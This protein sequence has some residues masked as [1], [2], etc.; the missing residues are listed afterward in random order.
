MKTLLLFFGLSPVAGAYAQDT[1]HGNL[2]EAV[3]E[4]FSSHVLWKAAPASVAVIGS[5]EMNRYAGTSL[6]PV[7][8]TVAG[9]RMEERSPASYRLSFRGSLLRSPFGV[10]NIKV[11]WNDIP[12][13]DGGGNTYLN[14]IDI[15]QVTG[16]EVIK[17]PA[18]S[19]YGA[20]TGGAL[21]LQSA[22]AYADTSA[23]RF[24]FGITGGSYGLFS[25]QYSWN[26]SD[27]H[28]A[29]SFQQLHQQSD[30]Y[31]EQSATRRDA[32]KWE[33]GIRWR[34]SEL[35]YFIFFTR[36][37]YQTPGGIT[38]V[39]MHTN[40]A[41]ARQPAGALPGAVQQKAAIDNK[42]AFTGIH[43]RTE[44]NDHWQLRSFVMASHTD[45]SNPFITN[46][47]KRKEKNAGIGLNIVYSA[48]NLQWQ[49]GV[50]WLYN[51]S[52]IDNYGNRS[53]VAD[54]LQYKDNVFANQWFLYSQWQYTPGTRWHIT[55][56]A[57]MNNQSY[58]YNRLSDPLSVYQTR[59][60]H[61]V[62]TPRLAVLYRISNNVSAYATVAKGFSPPTLAE[63][64]PSD[65]QFHGDLDAEYGWNY[66]A[67]IK[68]D[69]WQQRLQ[70]D[71]SVYYFHLQ[72][73]IVRRTDTAGA[74]F[75]VNAGGTKQTGVEATLKYQV[76]NTA[77]GWMNALYIWSSYAWQ[78]YRFADYR[79]DA[80]VFSGNAVTGVPQHGW[81][82]GADI[83]FRRG[84]YL[85]LSL[86]CT[87][88]LPL[89]DAN[90][91][92]ADAWHLLQCK[93][94]YRPSGYWHFFAGMDNILNEVY[95]LGN[96]INAAGYRFYNPAPG[97]NVF[98]GVM[99]N[100]GR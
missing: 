71:L 100:I 22:P 88:R 92:Y 95:S 86:N 70:Y 26:F 96:D 3:V 40:P 28:F 9:V 1:L 72:N 45:F 4:A 82:T 89:T 29:S 33:S 52:A 68:G 85:N 42:T 58:R 80:A 97:R 21:L 19:A 7:L 83:R 74:E 32:V 38:L 18:A 39:Q 93:F 87:S 17:G 24:A 25:E 20:G 37:N 44:L 54:T 63:F 13:T 55:A 30:G 62:I 66:E 34:K 41:L 23:N 15:S 51:Q 12:L 75:F 56:G 78:H 60:I 5:K 43:Y 11:Y 64:R 36:L 91:V 98:A 61:S 16:A 6:V 53:G 76:L 59:S 69:V 2:D 67:G 8:N 79:Q 31:R 73:A 94:G 46:Y 10:R 99:V 81:V 90:N 84:W 57:S 49:N 77:K 50:E 48:K 35:R 27:K 47:E 14:L 65:G